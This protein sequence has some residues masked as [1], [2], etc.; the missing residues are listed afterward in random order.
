M[1]RKQRKIFSGPPA[2]F[3]GEKTAAPPC[4]CRS[5]ASSHS[6]LSSHS[7][8][9][10]FP[11]PVLGML[12]PLRSPHPIKALA[13]ATPWAGPMA[14]VLLVCTRTQLT[15]TDAVSHGSIFPSGVEP[16]GNKTSGLK[17][18]LLLPR[19]LPLCIFMHGFLFLPVRR[20]CH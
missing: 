15:T 16:E 13:L 20:S 8:R 17:L 19:L 4:G 2:V 5:T 6:E 9:L 12:H 14:G 11:H 10:L 7:A 1:G 3:T 18:S